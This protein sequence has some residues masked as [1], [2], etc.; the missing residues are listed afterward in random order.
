MF[1]TAGELESHELSALEGVL[2]V[3]RTELVLLDAC[4][5]RAHIQSHVVD[6][7]LLGRL[8]VGMRVR[9]RFVLPSDWCLLLYLQEADDAVSWCHGLPMGQGACLNVLPE[10][11][12]E[13]S[14]S[15]AACLSFAL[16]PISRL[17]AVASSSPLMPDPP[18][19]LSGVRRDQ[20]ASVLH[21]ELQAQVDAESFAPDIVSRLIATHVAASAAPLY[22][23]GNTHLRTRRSRYLVFRRAE[24]FMR[25]N[26]R[27]QIYMQELCD[28]AGVSERLLRYAFEDLTGVSPSRYLSLYRLC[29]ACRALSNADA[30]IQS[31]KSVALDCGLW[32]LS[33]FADSYRRV[34]GELPRQ[35]LQR[36]GG[37]APAG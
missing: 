20:A 15:E 8:S 25:E 13:F 33:R 23:E 32:D 18:R 30:S 35:T 36:G 5:P 7:A 37:W 28:A 4:A 3:C 17:P 24:D 29:E 6:G 26:L 2:R 11:V 31:V 14:L 12:A 16:V 9:G 10:G 22:Y 34:F 21:R 27:R 1:S 19:L